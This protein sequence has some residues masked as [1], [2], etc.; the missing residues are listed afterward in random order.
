MVFAKYAMH[1]K[2][3]NFVRLLCKE[4]QLSSTYT[5]AQLFASKRYKIDDPRWSN[6]ACQ[7]N[8][9]LIMMTYLL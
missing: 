2:S 3:L 9:L 5:R 4:M 6:D 7:L 1:F 8:T